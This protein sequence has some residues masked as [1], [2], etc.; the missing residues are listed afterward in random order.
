MTGRERLLDPTGFDEKAADDTLAPRPAGLRGLTIG[1]LDNTKP[2]AEVLLT[3]IAGELQRR[4]GAGKSLMYTKGYFG[5][6]AEEDMLKRIA[7]ECDL[8]VTAVGDCGS[9]SAATVADGILLERAGIPTVSIVSDSFLVSGRAMAEVQGFPGFEFVAVRH[10][11]ASLDAEQLRE[12]VR[13]VLPDVLR[14]LGVES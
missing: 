9:C 12:R 14:I 2:N 8:V 13:D 6:P 7:K 11:V 1:L 4:Y 10:P 3:E 5:T